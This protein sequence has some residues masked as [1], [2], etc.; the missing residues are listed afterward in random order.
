MTANGR[1]DLIRHLKGYSLFTRKFLSEILKENV[2]IIYFYW[3]TE[4]R[5]TSDTISGIEILEG[6]ENTF[7]LKLVC[8]FPATRV[9]QAH[10]FT[11]LLWKPR[12]GQVK[13]INVITVEIPRHGQA[14]HTHW[15][16][17]RGNLNAICVCV[18]Y[19]RNCCRC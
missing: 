4:K 11:Y 19:F 13:H 1:W 17:Y 14:R 7:F 10:T 9:G 16:S 8:C 18:L 15:R 12:P 6:A 2:T 5:K 3:C